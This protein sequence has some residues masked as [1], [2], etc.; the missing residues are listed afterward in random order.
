MR[1]VRCWWRDSSAPGA[2]AKQ[3]CGRSLC[4]LD[5]SRA[6]RKGLDFA[7]QLAAPFGA[8]LTL[9]HVVNQERYLA[10]LDKREQAGLAEKAK[11][12]MQAL[13]R[14]TDFQGVKFTT[15]V[16][17]FRGGTLE[18][19]ICAYAA[20]RSMDLIVS[21]T[22][23]RTGLSHNLLGSVAEHIVREAK[24]PVLVVPTRRRR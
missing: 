13:V 6:S 10:P 16:P 24:G 9:L 8:A 3:R 18:D 2:P 12:E 7:I 20:H 17:S 11:E 23:G 15:A 22:H 14:R 21:T 1:L 19:A 4:H 5:F